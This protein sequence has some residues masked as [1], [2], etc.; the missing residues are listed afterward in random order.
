MF[1]MAWQKSLLSNESN[2]RM[3]KIDAKERQGKSIVRAHLS[4]LREAHKDYIRNECTFLSIG[5]TASNLIPKANK[6][7]RSSHPVTQTL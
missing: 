1:L 5:R 3:W 6:N 2:E 7:A 4:S